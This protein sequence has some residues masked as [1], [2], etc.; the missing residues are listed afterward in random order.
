MNPRGEREWERERKKGEKVH[1]IQ[2]LTS[3]YLCSDYVL[4]IRRNVALVSCSLFC[5]PLW[6][7]YVFSPDSNK[8]FFLSCFVWFLASGFPSTRL[9]VVVVVV[10]G[11]WT[12]FRPRPQRRRNVELIELCR[13]HSCGGGGGGGGASRG[14][15]NIVKILSNIVMPQIISKTLNSRLHLPL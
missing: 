13:I 2:L 3:R 15:S 6:T 1:T 10:S 7:K 14:G 8:T 12:S 9:V 4:P 11:V 5:F